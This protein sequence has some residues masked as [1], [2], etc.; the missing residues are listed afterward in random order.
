MQLV[1]A[2]TTD[3]R[4]VIGKKLTVTKNLNINLKNIEDIKHLQPIIH[5]NNLDKNVNYA[6]IDYL[7]KYYFVNDTRIINNDFVQLNMESD[8]LETYKD[9][10]L[11]SDSVVTARDTT[12]YF[13]SGLPT[14]IREETNKFESNVTLPDESS[15]LLVTIGG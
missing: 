6:Y 7:K 14:E 5:K 15:L 11:N 2:N 8:L 12:S 13:N 4:N 9:D 3:A 1:L 10:I